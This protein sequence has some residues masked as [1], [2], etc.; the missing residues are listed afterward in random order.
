[1]KK[2][3]I[4]CDHCGKEIGNLPFIDT[5][6]VD[7]RFQGAEVS[8]DLCLDCGKKMEKMLDEFCPNGGT[9]KLPF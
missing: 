5:A 6:F 1:M 9:Q 2:E 8:Y 7:F 3:T 4:I